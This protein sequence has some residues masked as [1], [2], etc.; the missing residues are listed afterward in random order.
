MPIYEYRCQCCNKR[1]SHFVRSFAS[2][3]SSRP[4][5]SH[6][7]SEDLRRLV[8]RIAVLG[9]EESRLDDL[10]DP[11]SL[12]DVD[13]NDPRSVGRW[14]RRMGQETGEDLGPEFSEVCE[15]LEAGQDPEAIERDLPGMGLGDD[16]AGIED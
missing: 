7:G 2:V 5:C 16:D 11:S 10:A 9:S 4:R 15:R 13:E 3:G 6:C 12:G 1:T 14:M 8:S